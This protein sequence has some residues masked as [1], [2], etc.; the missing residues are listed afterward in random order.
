[1]GLLLSSFIEEVGI[2]N[3]LIMTDFSLLMLAPNL[4]KVTAAVGLWG[5][6]VVSLAVCSLI[7]FYRCSR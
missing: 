5:W 7:M 2:F 4:T 3:L 1:M 6:I